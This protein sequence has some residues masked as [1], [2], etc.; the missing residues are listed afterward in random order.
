MRRMIRALPRKARVGARNQ[1]AM[2]FL[3][4]PI[5]TVLIP[6][7]MPTPLIPPMMQYVVEMGIPSD[8]KN[9]THTPAPN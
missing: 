2:I 5:L 6:F 9:R 8:V 3:T 4:S 7:D 1:F